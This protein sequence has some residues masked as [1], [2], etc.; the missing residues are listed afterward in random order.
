ML[1]FH[2]DRGLR[3]LG[4][5][6]GSAIVIYAETRAEWIMSAFGAFAQSITVSTLYT[7]LGDDAIIH[8][9]N[10]TGVSLVVTSHELLPKFRKML[11]HCPAVSTIVVMEDQLFPTTPLG[12]RR[13]SRSFPSSLR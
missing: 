6:P 9:L 5:A 4:V 10:E 11:D 1:T 7:N 12:T 8:G 2:L 3:E 13:G